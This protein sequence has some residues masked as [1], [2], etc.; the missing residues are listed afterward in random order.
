[1]GPVSRPVPSPRAVVAARPWLQAA[2]LTVAVATLLSPS[3]G[4]GFVWDDLQQIVRS[5][6]ITEP[7]A[8]LRYFS[9]NVVESYGSSGRGGNGVDTYRPLFFVTL[10]LV[11]HLDGA[12]PFWFH[13]A[14]LV[15]HLAVCLLLWRIAGRWLGSTGAAAAVFLVFAIHPVTA[16]ATLWASAI[17]EP[18]ATAGLLAAVLVLD[19]WGGAG[20]R[21]A[22]AAAAAGAAMLLGLLAKE[23]ILT[24]LPVVTL[25]LWRV[26]RVRPTGLAGPWIAAA[27]F[28]VMRTA[29]LG[30][31]QATGNDGGQR[32]E[33]I[34]N[35]PLLVVDGLRALVTLRPV[36]IR[37]LYWDYHGLSWGAS[38]AAAAVVALLAV[39]AW[40]VRRRLPLQLTALATLVAMMVPVALISTMP[41]WGG[42]GRY[43]YLPWAFTALAAAELGRRLRVVLAEHAPGVR[44]AVPVAITAFVA[45]EV[46]GLGRALEVY[47]SQESLARTAI[48]LQPHAPEGWLWLGNWYVEVGDPANAARC[49]AEAVARAPSA[50]RPR[51]NLAAALLA[52]GR[53]AEALENATAAMTDHGVTADGAWVAANACLELGLREQAARWLDRG[54]AVAPD[55]RPLLELRGRLRAERQPSPTGGGR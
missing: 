31:L 26:R 33:A 12:N 43:L 6:T 39:L 3:L 19:R 46:V 49:Y 9:L 22:V 5:P 1:M 53:P 42:F 23:A 47:R 44:W 41:G 10:W 4:A 24:A 37:H 14:V 40:R 21:P 27:V 8:P 52:L 2:L 38:G 32:L 13:L 28:L 30:G 16:E 29:A 17:S 35:L 25:Y 51:Q 48:E 54:L 18:L 36:G 45:L 11:H 7:N 15:A 55:D 34:R 50:Y 20:G